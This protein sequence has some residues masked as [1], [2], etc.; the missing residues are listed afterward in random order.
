MVRQQN[1]LELIS[2]Q[3]YQEASELCEEAINTHPEDIHSCFYLGVVYLLQGEVEEAQGVWMWT[4]LECPSELD[5]EQRNNLLIEIL[6][7]QAQKQT[8]L[9]N[10]HNSQLIY[11]QLQEL[12]PND[13]NTLLTLVKT[14]LQAGELTPQQLEEWQ[15][16]EQLQQLPPGTANPDLIL[17]IF[18]LALSFPVPGIE[19]LIATAF[20]HIENT[21]Q[22]TELENQN[23]EALIILAVTAHRTGKYEASVTLLQRVV[24]VNPE[25]PQVY[26]NLGNALKALGH[27][28]QA[29]ENYNKA[30]ELEPSFAEV[31]HNLGNLYRDQ[32]ELDTAKTYYQQA[33]ELN[34]QLEKTY[35]NLGL[36]ERATGNREQAIAYHEKLLAFYPNHAEG[37]NNLGLLQ[38][39]EGNYEKAEVSLKH[40]IQLK[41]EY[42]DAYNN[43]GLLCKSQG[44]DQEAAHYYQVA[45]NCYQ[46][47][48]AQDTDFAKANH[49]LGL[50]FYDLGELEQ[51]EYCYQRALEVKPDYPE[52]LNNLGLVYQQKEQLDQAI[53]YFNQALDIK[54][55]LVIAY[56]NLGNTFRQ[57]GDIETAVDYYNRGFQ[58]DP[59]SASLYYNFSEIHKYQ[60]EG[61]TYFENL[62]A[63]RKNKEIIYTNRKYIEFALAK[64]WRDIGN[65]EEEFTC[66]EEGNA[67]KR[68]EINYSV[69]KDLER[70]DHIKQEFNPEILSQFDSVF[71]PKRIPIFIVGM[72][73]SGTTL[74]EQ[75]LSSH[76]QVAGLGELRYLFQTVKTNK[77]LFE[78]LPELTEEELIE[79]R[80]QYL[81]QVAQHNDD[82]PYFTD[83]MPYNFQAVG[84]IKILF[85]EA[86]IIHCQRHPLDICLANYQRCFSTGNYHSYNLDEL[87]EYYL[88]YYQLMEHWYSVLPN[89]MCPLQYENLVSNQEE[90]SRKLLQFCELN[91]ED[92]VLNFQ[93]N[94]RAISTASVV[95]VRQKLYTSSANKWQRY[96]K[97]LEPLKQF[98]E[99]KGIL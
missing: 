25:L 93:E 5:G 96:A 3:R 51:A 40:S 78:N 32:G 87:G 74:T 94:K 71:E 10:W 14:S 37:Y 77:N 92:N 53:A 36:L 13:I 91:W 52:L 75:I 82:S 6:Q 72:P 4:M 88:G 57:K 49:N 64:A 62:L 22:I 98:F 17:E 15:V 41:P 33:L 21:P 56:S 43:L 38:S 59:N 85:P 9:E 73:R 55:D 48:K 16:E 34:S 8:D 46:Q 58:I 18:Q 20:E 90:E 11:Q 54:P 68:Q 61:D 28:E 65:H 79:A 30:I 31:Y 23:L 95:Q 42:A 70:F 44:R 50:L 35:I 24:A 39:E 97:H 63:L 29:K 47:A 27:L 89:F 1:I 12:V 66:L 45:M 80:N 60:K 19:P 99:E 69:D 67:I 2:T 81:E 83:K 26:S 76:S 84:L 86:K 7:T